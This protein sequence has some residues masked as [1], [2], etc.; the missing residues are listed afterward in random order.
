MTKPSQIGFILGARPVGPVAV[1]TACSSLTVRLIIFVP[2]SPVQK[3]N[4]QN[5][6]PD[7]YSNFIM[8]IKIVVPIAY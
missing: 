2:S 3:I 7:S 4:R 1:A 5:S 6:E 8:N